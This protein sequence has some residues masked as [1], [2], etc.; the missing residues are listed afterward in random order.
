MPTPVTFV[1]GIAQLIDRR[2][3]LTHLLAGLDL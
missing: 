2:A 3:G 1:N